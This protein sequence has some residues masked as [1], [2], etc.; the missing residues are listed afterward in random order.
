MRNLKFNLSG[1]RHIIFGT[2]SYR[3]SQSNESYAF[4]KNEYKSIN[5]TE[6]GDLI[7]PVNDSD[8][9]ESIMNKKIERVKS[10]FVGGDE[11]ITISS[12]SKASSFFASECRSN[13]TYDSNMNVIVP[14]CNNYEKKLVR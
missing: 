10:I 8:T 1:F 7:L 9:L 13:I 6:E 2:H 11:S 4:F 5:V 3:I 14:N 12:S